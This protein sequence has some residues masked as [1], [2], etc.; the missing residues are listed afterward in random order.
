[1]TQPPRS[2]GTPLGPADAE[3]RAAQLAALVNPDLVMVLSHIAASEIPLAVEELS[4]ATDLPSNEVERHLGTLI[5]RGLA[6]QSRTQS[7]GFNPTA[8]ALIHFGRF[9]TVRAA[10]NHPSPDDETLPPALARVVDRLA[11][12]FAASFS[13]ETVSR[14]VAD[15]YTRLSARARIRT[16]ILPM[17]EKFAADR[18]SALAVVEGRV[19]SGVPEVLFVCTHNAGR[20]QMAAAFL[21]RE[22]AEQVHVRTAGTKP[23]ARVNPAVIAAMA[24]IGIDMLQEFP[25]PLTDE[26][27]LASDVVITMGCGDSCPVYPGRRY[28]NWD[29]DDPSGQP[30]DRVRAIRDDLQRRVHDLIT[31][32]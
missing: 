16:H 7:L 29:I 1:M 26:V 5:D 23:A 14:L 17:T 22:A 24:E 30:P 4:A 21:R 10:D 6:E 27:V 11:Y 8:E 32:L 20:S 13:R 19:A 12:R 31:S 15:S 2:H 3:R 25:K 18:L 9:L 28:L